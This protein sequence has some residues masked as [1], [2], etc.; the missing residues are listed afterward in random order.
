MFIG[1]LLCTRHQAKLLYV[2]SFNIPPPISHVADTII[3]PVVPIKKDARPLPWTLMWKNFWHWSSSRPIYMGLEKI[4]CEFTHELCGYM[5][6]CLE[7]PSPCFILPEIYFKIFSYRLSSEDSRNLHS[8]GRVL[9]FEGHLPESASCSGRG[10]CGKHWKY[11][12]LN[13]Q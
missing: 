3:I 12:Y 2:F 7:S 6:P 8:R 1:H 10:S 4:T 5:S 9:T 11:H 13:L